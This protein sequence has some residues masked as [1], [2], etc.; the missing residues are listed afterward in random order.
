MNDQKSNVFMKILWVIGGIFG[1]VIL[2]LLI[3]FAIPRAVSGIGNMAAS[4]SSLISGKAKNSIEVTIN[5][6]SINT[7]ESVIVSWKDSDTENKTKEYTLVYSCLDNLQM[8][9]DGKNINCGIQNDV[10]YKNNQ[11]T[12]TTSLN[13]PSYADVEITIN[14]V[15]DTKITGKGTETLTVRGTGAPAINPNVNDNVDDDSAIKDNVS[16]DTSG[17]STVSTG[18]VS[19]V[20]YNSSIPAD[21]S[22]SNIQVGVIRNGVFVNDSYVDSNETPVIRFVI[23]NIGGRATGNWYFNYALPTENV[24]VYNS[25]IQS[26]LRAGDSIQY[27]IVFNQYSK[28][29]QAVG[30]YIDPQNIVS[31][32]NE[33][34]NS[35]FAEMNFEVNR[36]GGSSNNS[37][38]GDYD[39]DDEADLTVDIKDYGRYSNGRFYDENEVDP[40]DD[41]A[42]L[43]RVRNEGGESTGSWR[44]EARFPT[45]DGN[46]TYRSSKQPSLAPGEYRDIIMEFDNIRD[47]GN[48]I[49]FRLEVDSEDDVNEEREGNNTDSI[50]IKLD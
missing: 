46:E 29:R 14:A 18:N 8:Q 50:T 6:D 11:A 45:E 15:E 22:I 25:G 5:K 9:L 42:V 27:T 20:K 12:L 16:T 34:N 38:Y 48:S 44:F 7:G 28:G 4:I 35:S 30:I 49:S 39:S 19:T 41:V 43:F 10:T 13:S 31:E 40:D 24:I 33:I 17:Q 1:A 37:G 21:L 23:S 47:S 26:S 2:A 3:L 36:N 32:S